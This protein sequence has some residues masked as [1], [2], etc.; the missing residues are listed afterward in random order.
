MRMNWMLMSFLVLFMST[1]AWAGDPAADVNP[2]ADLGSGIEK[3]TASLDRLAVLLGQKLAF[4]AEERE[5]RR[6]EVAVGIMGLRYRKI[7]RLEA[8]IQQ[9]SREEP[10]LSKQIGLMKAEVDQLG[11]QAR[12]DSGEIN[13]AAKG[14]MELME[15]RIR[16]EEERLARLGQRKVELQNDVAAEQRRLG[17]LEAILEAWMEKQ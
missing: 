5:A 13:E 14:E 16:M 8:E 15:R 4:Q 6:V 7:D 2:Q 17:N 9:T 1:R 11:K 10:E 12:V 3:L